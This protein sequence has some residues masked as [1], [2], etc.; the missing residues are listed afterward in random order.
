MKI[1]KKLR[2]LTATE[3]KE[4][5]DKICC[6]Y[7]SCSDCPL[8]NVVCDRTDALSWVNYK[9]IFSDEFLDQE[10][11]IKISDILTKED[12]KYLEVV[13]KPVY[14]SGVA[15]KFL[16]K[17]SSTNKKFEFLE[18]ATDDYLC[19]TLYF[20]K[21]TMFKNMELSKTYTPEELGLF[22]KEVSEK[23]TLTN[24][25]KTKSNVAIHCGTEEKANRLLQAF[26]KL[27]KKWSEGK[28]Y[29]EVNCWSNYKEATC[30][31]NNRGY[32]SIDWY[33]ASGYKVY[34]FEDI[35][36]DN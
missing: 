32:A 30:Y 14:E 13:L 6:N 12:K 28:S 19:N 27:G 24:F 8:G 16:I 17:H 11:K 1:K 33:K 35:D 15:I 26:D 25:W 5:K 2:D 20:K 7:H 34:E 31:S 3:Y 21:G 36:L 18:C 22:Q 9:E 23:I 29:L 10:V 4:Y